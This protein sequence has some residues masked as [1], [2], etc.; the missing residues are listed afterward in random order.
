MEQQKY[1]KGPA[2][3]AERRLCLQGEGRTHVWCFDYLRILALFFVVFMHAAAGPMRNPVTPAWQVLNFCVSAAFSAVPLFFM[4]SGYLLL[5]DERTADIS[6]LLKQ[7]LPKLVCTLAVW[8]A[9][10]AAWGS[11]VEAGDLSL[12]GARLAAAFHAPSWVHLWYMYTLIGLYILS[13]VLYGAL[14]GMNEGGRRFLMGLLALYCLQGFVTALSPDSLRENLQLDLTVNLRI[15]GGHLCSFL[16]GYYLGTMKKKIS[17]WLLAAAAAA[18]LALI[19]WGTLRESRAAGQYVQVFH[20]QSSGPEIFLAGCIFVLF[21]QYLNKDSGLRR[22][23]APAV[24]LSLGI[25]LM[26]NFVLSL[27][28]VTVMPALRCS[29]VLPVTL[30]V[31]AVSYLAVKTLATVPGICYLTAG[32]DFKGACRSSNWIWT[33]ARVKKFFGGGEENEEPGE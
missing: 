19:T 11:W 5:T 4:M 32:L 28:H 26:H 22:C 8:S 1:S 14:R 33:F 27:L 15:F 7:R 13:P 24:S 23:L 3:D 25:Y 10:G 9:V 31:T 6:F 17:P 20:S 21:I 16:L 29:Q 18:D 30:A 12:F 2:A